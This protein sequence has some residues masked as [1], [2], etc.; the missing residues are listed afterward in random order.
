M[1][2]CKHCKKSSF[3]NDEALRAHILEK[4]ENVCWK[5]E[6]EFRSR[7]A[8]KAHSV[9]KH[10]FYYCDECSRSCRHYPTKEALEDH[11]KGKKHR[12]DKDCEGSRGHSVGVTNLD[13]RGSTLVGIGRDLINHNH[14]YGPI[15]GQYKPADNGGVQDPSLM[16]ADITDL[17]CKTISIFWR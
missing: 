7:S 12:S 6:A 17:F 8:F 1:A 2:S 16:M 14:F 10:K 11:A 3:G 5:C 13:A 9:A 4:H 15:N